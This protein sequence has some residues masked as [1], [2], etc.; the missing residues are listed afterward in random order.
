MAKMESGNK[1][2]HR[3]GDLTDGEEEWEPPTHHAVYLRWQNIGQSKDFVPSF[4]Q[5]FVN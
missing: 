3:S 5:A 2:R 1:L 4:H